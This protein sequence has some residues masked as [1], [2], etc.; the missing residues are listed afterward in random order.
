MRLFTPRRGRG[1]QLSTPTVSPIDESVIGWERIA[2]CNVSLVI[3]RGCNDIVRRGRASNKRSHQAA[4]NVAALMI[5]SGVAI[6][7]D[8]LELSALQRDGEDFR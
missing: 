3:C 5:G 6:L 7:S 8:I 2:I 4:I 1:A